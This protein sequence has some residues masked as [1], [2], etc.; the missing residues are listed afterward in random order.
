MP[1][2]SNLQVGF[3]DAPALANAGAVRTGGVDDVWREG[4]DSVINGTW[5]NDDATLSEPLGYLNVTQPIA[6]GV[7]HRKGNHLVGKAIA[8][9]C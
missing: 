4:L 1:A 9:N 3:V 6:Q 7:A 5:V 8:T 2:S